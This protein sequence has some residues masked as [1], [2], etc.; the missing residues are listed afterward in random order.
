MKADGAGLAA[1][2]KNFAEGIGALDNKALI[3][4]GGLMGIGG[5]LGLLFGVGKKSLGKGLKGGGGA[6]FGLAAIGAGVA[7]FFSGLALGDLA[8]SKMATDGKYIGSIMKN[9][10]EGL[11]AFS[12]AN[13]FAVSCHFTHGQVT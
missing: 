6:L 11:D 9:V 13:I 5:A 1:F 3:T 7:G 10:G 8:M 4:V 12:G 2:M